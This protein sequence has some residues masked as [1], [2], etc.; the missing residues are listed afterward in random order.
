VAGRRIRRVGLA[1]G[2][3]LLAGA[4]W[5]RKHPSACPYSARWLLEVP[6]PNLTV[7]PLL[8]VLAPKPGERIL[9]VGP[10]TGYHALPVAAAL[11]P[12]GTLD[13][14]DVQQPMLDDLMRRAAAQGIQN[15]VPTQGDARRL[16]YEDAMFDGAYL[17]TVLG[18]IPD[19][20]AALR[21]L[22]R[23]L[24]PQ[25]RLV[26]GETPPL[27]PHFVTFGALRSRAEAVGLVF[28]ERRGSPLLGYLA[29]FRKP[30]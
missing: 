23:V 21:E 7:R 2:A 18:E 24:K 25:G 3:G 4:V 5:A 13:A 8:V 22:I 12:D 16:P 10:G 14:F 20:D 11:A 6:R 9:E 27:D 30:S 17:V 1:A 15:I 19:Q 29:R 28:E 26:F